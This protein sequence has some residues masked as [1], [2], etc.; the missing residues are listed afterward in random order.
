MTKYYLS[1]PKG[2][3]LLGGCSWVT[4]RVP[5][6]SDAPAV[7]VANTQ[8]VSW[9]SSP[10]PWVPDSTALFLGGC[11]PPPSLSLSVSPFYGTWVL[12]PSPGFPG[13]ILLVMGGHPPWTIRVPRLLMGVLDLSS[14]VVGGQMH[15]TPQPCPSLACIPPR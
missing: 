5:P 7:S 12:C 1:H 15:V 4:G 6:A 10:P 13:P 9:V 14:L 11:P 8:P 3:G 2:G